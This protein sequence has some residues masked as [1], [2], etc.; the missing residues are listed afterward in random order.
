MKRDTT[1]RD[2][3][4]AHIRRGNPACALCGEP[5]DYSLPYLHPQSYVV[6]HITPLAHGGTDTL[7]NKQATHR[8]CNRSKG[9]RLDGGPVIKRSGA[10]RR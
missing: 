9:A 6:D 3:H 5:V 4:R 1:L 2:R 10:L 8:A 7:N